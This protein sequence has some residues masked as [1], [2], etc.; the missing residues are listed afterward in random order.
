RLHLRVP[1]GAT[2]ADPVPCVLW[3]H[4]GAGEGG[5][6][7][8]I[9]AQPLRLVTEKRI[10]IASVDYRL[11]SLWYG[12]EPNIFPAQI[13]DLKG[14][15]RWLRAHADQYGLDVECFGAWGPSAGGHLS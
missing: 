14:A 15:I 10:A 9:S 13:Q 12:G 8:A 3:I 1:A 2:A 7:W 5:N 11:T 6:A 4:G